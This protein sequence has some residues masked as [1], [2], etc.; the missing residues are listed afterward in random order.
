MQLAGY[1]RHHDRLFDLHIGSLWIVSK[2][3]T[4]L[5]ALAPSNCDVVGRGAVT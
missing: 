1:V 4:T 2:V 5:T 3:R